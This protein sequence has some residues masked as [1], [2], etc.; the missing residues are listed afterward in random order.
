MILAC[1][2]GFVAILCLYFE[3]FLPGGIFAVCAVILMLLGSFL[4]I[5]QASDLWMDALYVGILLFLSFFAC[6]LALK[7]IKKSKNSFCLHK[8]QQGYVSASFDEDLT[9][10]KG[11]VSTELKPSGHVRIEGK[12]YQAIS[13]GDFIVQGIEVEVVSMKGSHLIVK[14][15][16]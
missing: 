16:K 11:V 5:W 14:V 10:K 6:L 3:F 1:F 4:F 12:V 15:K 13:Q 8:D 2:I 9:R 7:N